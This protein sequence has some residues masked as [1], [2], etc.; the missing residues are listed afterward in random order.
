MLDALETLLGG[1]G[2]PY[3]LGAEPC[4]V[5][6]TLFGFL[7]AL[8]CGPGG[9]ENRWADRVRGSE[10]LGG[11]VDRIR[12]RYFSMPSVR[13]E[14]PAPLGENKGPRAHPPAAAAAATAAGG[15]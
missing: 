14:G 9:A 1:S 15:K 6:A 13:A 3:L 7:D 4:H 11:Y 2:G 5:D 8:A 10:V 12:A